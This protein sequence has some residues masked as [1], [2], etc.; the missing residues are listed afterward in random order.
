MQIIDYFRSENPEHWLKQIQQYEWSAARFLAH[1]LTENLFH[2]TVGP[3]TL[4]L[5]AD[6]ETL[7]SF[8][9]LARRDEID[10]ETLMPWIGFVHTAPQYRG[11]RYVGQLIDHAVSLAELHGVKRVYL[12]TNHT[13]LYEKYGF[14]FMGERA[15]PDG[16]TR[17][18][19][20]DTVHG[21]IRYERLTSQNFHEDSLDGFI[22]HQEVSQCWRCVDGEWLLLP[23]SFVED[24]DEMRL[25]TEAE[26]IVQAIDAGN[27]IFGAFAGTKI[28]GFAALG[29]RLGSRRQYRELTALQVSA[30]Y[31]GQ[32]IGKRLFAM[33]RDA[34]R[35][36]GAEKLYISAHSSRESQ[37]AYRAMGCVHATEPD[38][39]HAAAEP[40]DVQMEVDLRPE[41]VVR[42]GQMADLPSWMT[43]VREVAWNFPG[44]ETD[45]ALQEHADTVA[46]F[47]SKGNAICAVQGTRI[48]GVMLFSR[49]LNMLCCMAVSPDCRR[50][51]IATKMFELMLTLADPIRDLTVTTF[52]VEDPKGVAP[53]AFYQRQGFVPADL[54]T[55]NDYPCQR[56]IRKASI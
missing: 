56:F 8:L 5:L 9:T 29:G 21:M 43:L 4:L 35:C 10:D 14:T 46:K 23:I 12:S 52:C 36:D 7:V 32:G 25:R 11:H 3:G 39:A 18:Y 17:L 1:L 34:A 16:L 26:E 40:A 30:P 28:V 49:R 27:T 2:E 47:I 20:R 53:R 6:G 42:F 48:V 55:E 37:A 24:W 51:G 13:G 22:R 54:V 44:L 38:A 15:L 45:E 31:R 19:K 50:Q 33:A 41:T